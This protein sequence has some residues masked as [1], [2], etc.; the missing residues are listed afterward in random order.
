MSEMISLVSAVLGAWRRC[1]ILGQSVEPRV[2]MDIEFSLFIIKD[3]LSFFFQFK[4][5]LKNVQKWGE[6]ILFQEE[7]RFEKNKL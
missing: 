1:S 6:C 7:E 3:S 5:S 2:R 4:K